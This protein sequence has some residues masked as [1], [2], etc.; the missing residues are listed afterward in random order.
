MPLDKIAMSV[1]YYGQDA[2]DGAK[3]ERY[4]AD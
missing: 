4:E 2:A 3:G 1:E